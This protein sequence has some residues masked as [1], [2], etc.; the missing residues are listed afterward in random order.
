MIDDELEVVRNVVL[1]FE[2][3]IQNHVKDS[4]KAIIEQ[5]PSM[6]I[7][8]STEC[9]TIVDHVDGEQIDY[10]MYIEE[11]TVNIEATKQGVSIGYLSEEDELY[12]KY[13]EMLQPVIDV[14]RTFF[15]W[16]GREFVTNIR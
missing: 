5:Y 13:I 3:K 7:H 9:V 12:T 10:L 2:Y 16:D 6:S 15:S 14:S 1:N 8:I 11:E 4:I